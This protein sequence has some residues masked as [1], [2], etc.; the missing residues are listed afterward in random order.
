MN[1]LIKL[2]VLALAALALSACET[3]TAVSRGGGGTIRQAGSTAESACMQAVNGNYGGKVKNLSVVSSEFSQANS[4]VMLNADGQR[5]RCL[6][7]SDGKVQ[8][9]SVVGQ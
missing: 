9:L 8:D 2:P 7:S 5:W 6:V 4:E 1:T 3:D